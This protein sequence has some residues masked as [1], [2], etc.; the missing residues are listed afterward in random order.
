VPGGNNCLLV[1]RRL[2]LKVGLENAY[3]SD[4]VLEL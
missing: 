4:G 1:E 2:F 3:V